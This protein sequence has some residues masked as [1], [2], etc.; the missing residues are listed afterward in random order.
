[1]GL[2][3]DRVRAELA[4]PP[5]I[6]G[7]SS[8][9]RASL[10]AIPTGLET[11]LYATDTQVL[12]D[13]ESVYRARTT[14]CH[15]P[16][17]GIS[18]CMQR[19]FSPETYWT[20]YDARTGAARWTVSHPS[21]P[22]STALQD[23]DALFVQTDA[24]VVRI[25][26]RDG[27]LSTEAKPPG[28]AGSLVGW[29][30]KE[31]LAVRADGAVERVAP[32]TLTV[33]ASSRLPT[34]FQAVRR[35]GDGLFVVSDRRETYLFDP[36]TATVRARTP[37][38]L[39]GSAPITV[40][41]SADA[42]LLCTYEEE[43]GVPPQPEVEYGLRCLDAAGRA[44]FSRRFVPIF[45]HRTRRVWDAPSRSM[46]DQ[47]QASQDRVPC[48]LGRSY[49]RMCSPN[50][51]EPAPRST[52]LSLADGRTLADLPG[53]VRPVEDESGRIVAMVTSRS[54]DRVAILDA[55]AKPLATITDTPGRTDTLAEVHDGKLIVIRARG[56]VLHTQAQPAASDIDVRIWALDL[57]TGRVLWQRDIASPSGPTTAV[58]AGSLETRR[59]GGDLLLLL[60]ADHAW[61]VALDLGTGAVRARV[62]G[63]GQAPQTLFTF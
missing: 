43:R 63:S 30:G 8:L 13:A 58:L 18:L 16:A 56:V 34:G 36:R 54:T 47:H 46:I 10:L 19:R 61:L 39:A 62:D 49:W 44:A 17:M 32:D 57:A 2:S 33:T 52:I 29:D 6:P 53:H 35:F 12:R 23:R 24:G 27:A 60:H 4:A 25:A 11:V 21:R 22:F 9:A 7:V 15:E 20:A 40:V 38:M 50:L 14:G 28:R 31:L 59:R 3:D 37:A 41:E 55:A 1:M 48:E 5:A 42:R 51:A 26:K 45:T